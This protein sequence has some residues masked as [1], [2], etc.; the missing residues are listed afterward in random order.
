MPDAPR[1]SIHAGV[2]AHFGLRRIKDLENLL[3][4]GGSVFKNLLAGQRRSGRVLARRISD[5]SGEV[6]NQEQHLMPQTPE[7]GA[8]C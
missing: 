8:T 7:S 1:A 2:E 5:H 4:I 3:L 6:A